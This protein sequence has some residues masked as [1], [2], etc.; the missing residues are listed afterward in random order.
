MT[1]IIFKYSSF[2]RRFCLCAV[3]LLLCGCELDSNSDE[4]FEQQSSCWQTLVVGAVLKVID[5]LYENASSVVTAS[6]AGAAV[7]CMGFSI[8]M[9]FKLL[10]ILSSFKEQN[11]GEMW[12][13][14]GHKLFLCGFCAL[15]LASTDKID[16]AMNTFVVPIYNTILELGA[17]T[18]SAS[19]NTSSI[20]MGEFGEVEYEN[21]TGYCSSAP[22]VKVGEGTGSLRNGIEPMANCLICSINN[23]LNSGVLIGVDLILSGTVTGI[24]VGLL[25]LVIYTATKLF[26]VLFVV[27][28]LFRLNFAAFLIP[29]LIIGIP[30]NYTRKW[31]KQGFLLFINSAGCMLFIALLSS[32]AIGTLE[33]IVANPELTSGDVTG[34]GSIMLS[35]VMV[36]VLLLNVPGVAVSLSDKFIGG[37]GSYVFQE[38]MSKFVMRTGRAA[39]SKV[40]GYISNGVTEDINNMIEKTEVGRWYKEKY[41]SIKN[42]LNAAAGYNSQG[43]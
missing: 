15:M 41:T 31:S 17:E 32:I 43:D 21:V 3:M 29:V 30:F 16:W 24:F 40:F 26:F 11:I 19:Q 33:A 34:F 38:A 25:V 2:L 6:K 22:N 18:L 12:T 35:I 1:N 36:S 20:S 4:S 5:S 27:D 39:L 8:W 42:K 13:E 7:I 37:G 28:G 23:R 14:I 9:A 10:K